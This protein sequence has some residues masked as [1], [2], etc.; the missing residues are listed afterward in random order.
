MRF[1]STLLKD[2]KVEGLRW[3]EPQGG[4]FLWAEL[5]DAWKADELLKIAVQQG[6]A[7]VPGATFY[8]DAPK[9]NTIRLNFTHA[10]HEQMTLGM[11]RFAA[12]L[13]AMQELVNR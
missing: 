2:L 6:V 1:M 10:N 13:Q 8:A 7:F 12:S 3:N 4:M 5:P 11:Q 9:F